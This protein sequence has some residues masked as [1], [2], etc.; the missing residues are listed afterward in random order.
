M[1]SFLRNRKKGSPY[2][3]T[4]A[5]RRGVNASI[6]QKR[7]EIADEVEFTIIYHL[8]LIC[9][10]TLKLI[11]FLLKGTPTWIFMFCRL[12]LFV[13]GLLP[14]FI[15]FTYYYVTYPIRDIP[16]G[17]SSRHLLDIY[18]PC[19]PRSPHTPSSRAPVLVFFTGG[20]WIIGY[21]MWGALMGRALCPHGL[22]LV[23]PDYRNFP[24]AHGDEMLADVDLAAQWVF[25]N[26]SMYGGDP[27]NVVLVGQSAGAHL[28]ALL[29][30][31]KAAASAKKS[32]RTSLNLIR[33]FT[34]AEALPG[35]G[36]EEEGEEE[37]SS[38]SEE[39]QEE[40]GGAKPDGAL[41]R[42]AVPAPA[43][44][45]P[46][47]S[48]PPKE[49]GGG[50]GASPA[51]PKYGQGDEMEDIPNPWLSNKIT[52]QPSNLRGFIPIS[53]PYDLPR[54]CANFQ[55]RGLDHSI[56]EWIFRNDLKTFS[57]TLYAQ[58]LRAANIDLSA[59]SFPPLTVIC[60]SADASVAC[61]ISV[62]FAEAAKGCGGEVDHVTY[63][64]WSHTDPILE[65][66]MGGDQRLHRDI[67][68]LFKKW[69]V[70][71]PEAEGGW[72]EFPEFD[73]TIPSCRRMT[74]E[75]MVA[76]ARYCNPF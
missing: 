62:A 66:P 44:Q 74:P 33:R 75:F 76:V 35:V 10:L 38:S 9:R 54:L 7:R 46:A 36:E 19:S 73:A 8:R 53:G 50:S 13:L 47:P 22:L 57:P 18:P 55:K 65:K 42:S 58:S 32:R 41:F 24:Q 6:R 45:R 56:V 27:E 28:T 67:Y 26:I 25:D 1:Q 4:P 5:D 72:G 70:V 30:L 3:F 37:S 20:A 14:G 68:N 31:M 51:S 21:K 12:M 43:D 49:R 23:I 59:V 60:G 63:E 71:K 17:L 69:C 64:G 11:P 15:V 39:E 40:E 34:T 16:Y 48:S 2:F 29:L 52:W 61:D